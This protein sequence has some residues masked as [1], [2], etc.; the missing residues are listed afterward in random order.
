MNAKSG[1][2]RITRAQAEGVKFQLPD[3]ENNEIFTRRVL[4]LRDQPGSLLEVLHLAQEYYGYLRKDVM[5]W[6][7]QELKIPRAEVYD[8]ASF[9]TMFFMKPEAKYVISACDCLSCYLQGSETVWN[10]IRETAKI[11][12]GEMASSDGLFSMHVVSCLG[13]CEQS[14]VIMINQERY[15]YLT[16][17]KAK[18]I[19][20]D[21]INQE[22]VMEGLGK[23]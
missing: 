3:S 15:G 16:P 9:Y 17:E 8:T 6:I 12:Q 13:A 19:I 10:A 11:P 2:K 1:V 20:A 4:A 5:G 23:L 22:P 14:P 7:S 18:K 21:L